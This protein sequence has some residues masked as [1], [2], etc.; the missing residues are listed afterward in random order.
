M[1]HTTEMRALSAE[2]IDFVAGGDRHSSG[3]NTTNT[4]TQINHGTA[5]AIGG[6][7]ENDGSAV[8]FNKQSNNAVILN[9]SPV[10]VLGFGG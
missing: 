3:G 2:E 4:I 6:G 10:L 5:V 7:H 9:N 1:T 8:A